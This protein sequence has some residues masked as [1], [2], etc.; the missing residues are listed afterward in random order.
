MYYVVM[1]Y[2]GTDEATLDRR[3]AARPAHREN[4]ARMLEQGMLVCGDALTDDAGNVTGSLMVLEVSS[5]EEVDEWL[6]NEPFVVQ[7]VWKKT[8]ITPANITKARAL[9]PQ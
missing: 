7:G 9:F 4:A 3:N 6:R 1:A 8:E 5:R 2:D